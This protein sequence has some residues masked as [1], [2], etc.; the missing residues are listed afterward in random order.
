MNKK[1]KKGSSRTA[2]RFSALLKVLLPSAVILTLCIY[3]AVLLTGYIRDNSSPVIAFYGLE[4]NEI[5]GLTKTI[6]DY[7][8]GK[9][10]ECEFLSFD[11]D[12]PL[13]EILSDNSGISLLFVPGGHAVK[14]AV[15]DSDNNAFISAPEFSEL[16]MSASALAEIS[17]GKIKAA[18]VCTDFFYSDLAGITPEEADKIRTV[19]DLR[20]YAEKLKRKYE[21]PVIFAG[22]DHDFVLDMLG[23]F[24]E[25]LDGISSYNE[26]AEILKTSAG[27]KLTPA[28]TAALLCND[29]SSP[30]KTTSILFSEMYRNGLINPAA[31]TL[32]QQDIS[33]LMEAKL[34]GITFTTLSEHRQYTPKAV[35]S[36]I[37]KELPPAAERKERTFTAKPVFAVPRSQGKK[38]LEITDALFKRELQESISR[39]TGLAPVNKSCRTPDTQASDVRYFIAASSAPVSGLS[40][41]TYLSPDFK[42]ALTAEI[43][44][45]FRNR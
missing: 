5:D 22:K 11:A 29:H 37:S 13:E 30:L 20:K 25:S 40:R 31:H 42:K 33:A 7:S 19:S 26:A 12:K 36:F 39:N 17:E 8:A 16:T 15:K 44:T 6:E 10:I 9:S 14:S 45:S 4:K 27:K 38:T 1:A 3:G 2:S 24:A 32:N 34:C 18:P 21:N 23:A 41:E 35:Q 28:E 43:L